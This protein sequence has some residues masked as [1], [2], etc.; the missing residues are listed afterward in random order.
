[1]RVRVIL[2]LFFTT[3]LFNSSVFARGGGTAGALE[4]EDLNKAQSQ[5]QTTEKTS[6]SSA[7]K[8]SE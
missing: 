1:M 2:A 8:K 3:F 5:V 6:D 4:R 7:D